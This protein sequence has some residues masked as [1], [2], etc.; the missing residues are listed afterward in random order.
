MKISLKTTDL[1]ILHDIIKNF[2]KPRETKNYL[3]YCAKNLYSNF[4]YHE[5]KSKEIDV[6]HKGEIE[7]EA[8]SISLNRVEPFPEIR[9]IGH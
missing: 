4:L 3:T 9:S 7:R 5:S 6:N 1:Y 2:S 8:H